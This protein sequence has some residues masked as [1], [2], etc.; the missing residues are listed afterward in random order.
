MLVSAI[1]NSG[2]NDTFNHKRTPS[3]HYHH[4]ELGHVHKSL[5]TDRFLI[6]EGDLRQEIYNYEGEKFSLKH[7]PNSVSNL[8]LFDN[9]HT[10]NQFQIS[11]TIKSKKWNNF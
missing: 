8:S 3:S 5:C 7:R 1:P 10:F 2:Y 9:E 11:A 6:G 4:L